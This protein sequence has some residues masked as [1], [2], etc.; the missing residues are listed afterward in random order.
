MGVLANPGSVMDSIGEIL[1]GK[2]EFLLCVLANFSEAA[3][4]A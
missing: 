4:F 2:R 1:V 3:P